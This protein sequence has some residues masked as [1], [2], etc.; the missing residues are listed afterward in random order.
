M[1]HTSDGALNPNAIAC[2]SI[3]L[4]SRVL[5]AYVAAA[6]L[7]VLAIHALLVSTPSRTLRSR[8]APYNPFRSSGNETHGEPE[9]NSKIQKHVLEHG[10]P[11][12]FAH[13]IARMLASLVLLGLSLS[14]YAHRSHSWALIIHLETIVRSPS[15]HSKASI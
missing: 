15:L 3:R 1:R 12:I 4:E 6:C 7:L 9:A 8:F 13:Q 5:T 11:V 10:G 14:S 2:R